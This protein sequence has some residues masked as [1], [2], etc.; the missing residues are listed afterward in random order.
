MDRAGE[1]GAT[2]MIVAFVLSI[3]CARDY[4]DEFKLKVLA[5]PVTHYQPISRAV[6]Q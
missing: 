4:L 5:P 3:A 1:A 2:L 6:A